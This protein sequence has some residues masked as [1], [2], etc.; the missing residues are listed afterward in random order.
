MFKVKPPVPKTI[1]VFLNNYKVLIVRLLLGVD[2]FIGIKKP[3][4]MIGMVIKMS[5]KMMEQP[6]RLGGA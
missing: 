6:E 1:P 5:N 2:M 4:K 3:I